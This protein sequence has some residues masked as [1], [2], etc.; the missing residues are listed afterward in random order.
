MRAYRLLVESDSLE[1]SVYN[2][3]SGVPRLGYDFINLLAKEFNVELPGER[4]EGPSVVYGSYD[5]L[6]QTTG[7]TPEI[8]IE[9]TIKDFA[10]WRKAQI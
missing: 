9:Q 7:W 8:S 4:A 10:A 6:K 3:C 5:R 2:I 1:H